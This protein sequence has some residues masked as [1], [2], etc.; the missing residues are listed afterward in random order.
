MNKNIILL[1]LT[2]V[3]GCSTL[4]SLKGQEYVPFPEEDAYWTVS[5]FNIQIGYYDTYIYTVSGDTLVEDK[6]YKKIYQLS[7]IAGSNDTL[8]VLHNLMRQDT[9]NKKVYFIRI[10]QA[11]TTEKLGYDFDVEIGDTIHIPAFDYDNGGD[12]IFEV[13]QPIFDS[14]LLKNGEYRKN[15]AYGS[16][17]PLT[18]FSIFVI[19][20]VGTFRTPFP[21]LF[22]FD[23][24]HPSETTCHIVDGVYL[25]GSS[26]LPDF[27]D[28]SVK[29]E[30]NFA[31][32]RVS[33]Y[34]QPANDQVN[35][36]IEAPEI[37]N[38]NIKILNGLGSEVFALNNYVPGTEFCIDVSQY[39][40]GIYYLSFTSSETTI[41]K[42]LIIHH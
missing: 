3:F 11:E 38:G 15:Y 35:L 25:Y 18:G 41:T 37:S 1:L 16:L 21:N 22:Y 33:C 28:F 9:I 5:E 36:I 27:C 7:D 32:R 12:S 10:Y 4:S 26:P 8:W 24:F 14:T 17:H 30:E 23:P 6:S 19:E 29:V 31:Q 34:P 39:P 13:V 2:F 20:G 40:S 42:K